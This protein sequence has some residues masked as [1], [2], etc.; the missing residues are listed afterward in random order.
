MIIKI[1]IRLSIS[2]TLHTTSL[3]L[4]LTS[5]KPLGLIFIAQDLMVQFQHK[6]FLFQPQLQLQS[7]LPLL[8]AQVI[9]KFLLY[10][11]LVFIIA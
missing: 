3:I 7:L 2:I 4:I 1:Y 10:I 11:L 6:P 9:A 5:P 8:T